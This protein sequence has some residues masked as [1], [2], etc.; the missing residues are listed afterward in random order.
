[1]VKKLVFVFAL[2]L[3]CLQ[4]NA[5]FE[6]GKWYLNASLTGLDLSHSKYEGTNFGVSVG[7]GTFV[8]DNLA[9]LLNFKGKYVENGTDE[10]SA[11]AGV[12]YYFSKCGVYTGAGCAYK[13][14]SDGTGRENLFC[15]TPE[16]GYAFFINGTIT[17]E[18]S[19]YYDI[20][21][22]NCSDYS[23]LGFKIG[24]GFYF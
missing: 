4:A 7:G 8:A 23:K 13:H 9:V 20:S 2:L 22:K 14:L 11:G 21:F 12:R 16:L 18:P 1:M 6:K 17:V 15:L 24:F 10:T 19:V 5:Q 3:G